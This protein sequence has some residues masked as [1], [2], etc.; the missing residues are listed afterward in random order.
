MK[1]PVIVL[2]G[3]T[4]VGKTELSLELAEALNAEIVSADSMQVYRGM[5]IG[6]AKASP[7]ER[8]RVPHHLIDAADPSEDFSIARYVEL[9]REV[10]KDI[11][12][13]GKVSLI[14]GGTGFYIQALLKDLD[15]S[16]EKEERP[17]REKY[18]ILAETEG[19][20]ALHRRL[21]AIDPTAAAAIHANN[22]KRVIRALEYFEETGSRISALNEAQTGQESPYR[23][24]YFVLNLPRAELYRR[25]ELRVDQMMEEGL[26]EETR[27]LL[28]RN[29][30]P[31]STALQSIG[32]KELADYLKG[33][34]SLEEAVEKIKL[35]SR[36]YAKR[37]LTWFR[38]EKDAVWIDKNEIGQEE[39]FPRLLSLCQNFLSAEA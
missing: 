20:E 23:V 5:D 31:G 2:A 24:L 11:Q 17:L 14:V 34:C 6:T 13:R 28:A 16:E 35:N 37:Q 4:A 38:R 19:P 26:L 10:L 1:P 9:G 30:P 32:Y 12:A 3:P 8:A 15:F 22:I 7:E 18:R 33:T 27:K 25:I 36:H 39:L 21:K 29:V